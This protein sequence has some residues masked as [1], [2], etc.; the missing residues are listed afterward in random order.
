MQ[1][2]KPVPWPAP[3][4][5]PYNQGR[6]RGSDMEKEN[7]YSSKNETNKTENENNN[8]DFDIWD[9]QAGIM[10]KAEQLLKRYHDSEIH[11]EFTKNI[12]SQEFKEEQVK[13][14]Y[15]ELENTFYEKCFPI[16]KSVK[17]DEGREILI[18]PEIDAGKL[19]KR[20]KNTYIIK[21]KWKQ[22]TDEQIFAKIIIEKDTTKKKVKE[23]VELESKFDSL[24]EKIES[25]PPGNSIHR[26]T[27][28]R[29]TIYYLI[30]EHFLK[31]LIAFLIAL[32]KKINSLEELEKTKNNKT[33]EENPVSPKN[34]AQKE[35]NWKPINQ[36]V[37]INETLELFFWFEDFTSL[38]QFLEGL[39]STGFLLS[40][41]ESAREHFVV[42][43]IPGKPAGP[44]IWNGQ[45]TFAI[46]ALFEASSK[47]N[48]IN[49][50]NN[51]Q[52]AAT[53]HFVIYDKK[54]KETRPAK[55][56]SKSVRQGMESGKYDEYYKTI[57]NLLKSLP[58]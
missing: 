10:S 17:G 11:K 32:I 48:F 27:I 55:N 20:A 5:D 13:H 1:A 47:L 23:I 44:I 54:K 6:Y 7:K 51:K 22:I 14:V 33:I 57:E 18:P 2:E 3:L 16:L 45:R 34:T 9:S 4:A 53:Q 25:L 31:I 30:K 49:K 39:I 24:S 21:S 42:K 29:V 43:G 56:L 12:F 58:K 28:N 46:D 26:S 41:V 8:L 15:K 37:I 19:S 40:D 35:I 50:P 38:T 52:D 36:S